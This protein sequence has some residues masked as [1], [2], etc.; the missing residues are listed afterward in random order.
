MNGSTPITIDGLMILFGFTGVLWA[1]FSV[2]Q[3]VA[4]EQREQRIMLN[5]IC[6]HLGIDQG[7]IFGGRDK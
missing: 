3:R 2:Y 7:E 5:I 4:A 6:K 1:L